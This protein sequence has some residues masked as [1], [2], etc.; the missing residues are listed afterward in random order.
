VLS[1][2]QVHQIQQR[3]ASY[4]LFVDAL[5]GT[6]LKSEVRG[7]IY[8]L[9]ITLL[10]ASPTPTVAIDIPSGLSADSGQILG[11]H[12][13]A[14]CTVTLALP[15]RGL[16]L[17]PAA[18]AVGKL[19]VVDIGIPFGLLQDPAL[20][21][22]LLEER[23]IAHCLPV[24][25]V[26][27]HKG[28]YG[29]VLIIAGSPG[30]SGA[31]ALA[32]MGALR[33]GAG[34]VTYALPKSLNLAMESR[35]T[36]VMTFPLPETS[37]GTLGVEAFAVLE[38]LFAQVDVVVLGPGLSTHPLTGKLVEQVVREVALPVVID[39]DGL[40]HLASRLDLFED[41]SAPR[42]L[43]PH[44][45]EMARLVGTSTKAVQEHRLEIAQ[46]FVQKYGVYLILKGARTLVVCPDGSVSINPTGNAGMATA[47][48][49]DVLAGIVA[50]LIG[51]GLAPQKASQAAVFLHG[52]SGDLAA[53][54]K[55]EHGLIAGDLVEYLPCAL[56][57]MSAL[58]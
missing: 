26:D 36:E 44:P 10:N 55:G 25:E 50:G 23:E 13:W 39:A 29:H 21:I 7:G 33:S 48:T 11:V 56:R 43:T 9:I 19:E 38:P 20:Q 15:K 24:R 5:L 32:S 51:Q 57:Q 45:G 30:K 16:L 27:S 53:Q 31:G 49:G 18:Q 52:L 3:L 34:L 17:Y 40:N 8:A 41:T 46:E 47:G 12:V 22:T 2:T 4:G 58:R 1:D 28:L 14:D 35:L 37:E 54:A 6:G 42:I